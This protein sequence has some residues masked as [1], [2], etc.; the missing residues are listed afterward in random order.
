VKEVRLHSERGKATVPR[1][2]GIVATMPCCDMESLRLSCRGYGRRALEALLC[3]GGSGE[4]ALA[5]E[6]QR[7]RARRNSHPRPKGSGEP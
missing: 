1:V 2:V 5:P 4:A 6:P 3:A 7:G